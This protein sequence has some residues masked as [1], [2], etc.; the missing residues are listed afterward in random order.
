MPNAR[1]AAA[2]ASVSVRS[3]MLT[4]GLMARSAIIT[5]ERIWTTVLR[6]S[7]TTRSDF[8]NSNAM[9]TEP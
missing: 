6:R 2:Y 5:T 3:R 7:A 8:L 4:F 1:I 9:I